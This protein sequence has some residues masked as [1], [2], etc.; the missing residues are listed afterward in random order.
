ML[1]S[2]AQHK[3]IIAVGAIVVI[4]I[5]WYMLS[6]GSSDTSNLV[7]EEMDAGDQ[8]LIQSLQILRAIQLDPS[9][10][11]N[12]SYLSLRDFSTQIIPEPVGRPD[13]FAPLSASV[14]PTSQTMEGAQ[15]FK[16]TQ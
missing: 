7:T 2:F 16:S 12:P 6:S 1:N 10:F 14:A 3:I 9:I 5:A 8:E 13:P 15:I 11:S 4:G